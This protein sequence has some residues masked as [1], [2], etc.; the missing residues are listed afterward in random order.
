MPTISQLPAV[1][2][3]GPDDKVMFDQSG[4]S[5]AIRLADRACCDPAD[6]HDRTECGSGTR[7]E[8]IGRTTTGAARTLG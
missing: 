3:L 5:V 7:D 1:T 2:L 4:V 8:R 6:P